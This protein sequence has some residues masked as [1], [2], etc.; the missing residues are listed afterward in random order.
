MTK[1][2]PRVAPSAHVAEPVSF[3]RVVAVRGQRTAVHGVLWEGTL[4]TT[5][6]DTTDGPIPLEA[7]TG[8][9]AGC[10]V[11]SLRPAADAAQVVFDRIEMAISATRSD[12][13]PAITGLGVD[14]AIDTTATP[15]AVRDIVVDAI[16]R[17]TITRTLDRACPVTIT[18]SINRGDPEEL[19]HVD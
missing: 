1:V 4:N 8:A 15:A 17:G 12:D 3:M 14:L 18:L 5:P 9:L 6:D 11:R 19:P 10:F 16:G 7:L 2:E 13:P